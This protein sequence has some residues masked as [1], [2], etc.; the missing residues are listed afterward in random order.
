MVTLITRSPADARQRARSERIES[1]SS[2]TF[3][4]DM[5]IVA[6]FMNNAG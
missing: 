4:Q 3:N 6:P 1:T 2:R 5:G